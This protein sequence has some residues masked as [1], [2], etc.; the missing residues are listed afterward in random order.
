MISVKIRIF[1]Y[2]GNWPDFQNHLRLHKSSNSH[3]FIW[4]HSLYKYLLNVYN[5]PDTILSAKDLAV[6]EKEENLCP[7][8][9]YNLKTQLCLFSHSKNIK[10]VYNKNFHLQPRWINYKIW[11]FSLKQL[12]NWI[13]YTISFSKHHRTMLCERELTQWVQIIQIWWKQ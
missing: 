8:N 6:N 2:L 3:I 10:L 12:E 9:V 13:A 1:K 11:S 7:Q 5:I 4:Q